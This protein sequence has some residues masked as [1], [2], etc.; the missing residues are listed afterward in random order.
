MKGLFNTVK[1]CIRI[2]HIARR[3]TS[4]EYREIVKI[5]GMGMLVVGFIGLV[6]YLVFSVI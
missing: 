2:L 4:R 1:K 3:P 5:T 6:F